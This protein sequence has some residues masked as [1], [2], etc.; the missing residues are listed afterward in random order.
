MK[1]NEEGSN[2]SD[3]ANEIL[4]KAALVR[5]SNSNLRETNVRYQDRNRANFHVNGKKCIH[6]EFLSVVRERIFDGLRNER[7][8][9]EKNHIIFSSIDQSICS[10]TFSNL[11][12]LVI[13]R[14]KR[15]IPNAY[16]NTS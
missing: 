10:V 11:N 6:G 12:S 14:E 7:E 1:R 13:P 2:Q 9:K 3:Q 16:I 8:K 5:R 15:K 4:T